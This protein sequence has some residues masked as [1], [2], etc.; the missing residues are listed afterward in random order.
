MLVFLEVCLAVSD[1][2][3]MHEGEEEFV[4]NMLVS[5]K[6]IVD[7]AIAMGEEEE[8]EVWH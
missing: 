7:Q 2:Y 6:D 8:P 4:G 5:L 1:S 3:L